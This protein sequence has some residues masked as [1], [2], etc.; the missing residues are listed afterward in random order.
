MKTNPKLVHKIEEAPRPVT[1]KQVRS[2]L[3]LIGF[4][5]DYIPNYSDEALPLTMLTGKGMPDKVRWGDDQEKAFLKLK[6]RLDQSPILKL[7]DFDKT[8]ILKVDASDTGLGAALMQEFDGVEFPIAYA[9]KKLLPRERN[10][11]IIEKE[12]LAIVWAVKR[13][14]FFLYGRAF[15]IHTDHLPL[16][17]M[18]NKKLVN[19][20]IMRWAMALQEFRFRLVSIKGRDNLVADYLS[21]ESHPL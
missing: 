5:R 4:Y 21:R 20:R 1:K 9:S 19:K 6:Q 12:C 10:Y 14:E 16:T 17:F 13:F 8:F 2:F 15:E 3:G 11:A 7:P 18:N